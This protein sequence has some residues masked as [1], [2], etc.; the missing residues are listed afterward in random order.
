MKNRKNKTKISTFALVL[1]LTISVTLVALPIVIAHDP[2]WEIT[3]WC[4]IALSH[5]VI[6]RGQTMY[7]VFWSHVE[8]PTGLGAYGDR[9][10]FTVEV[11][12]PDGSKQTLG[13]ISSQDIKS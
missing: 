12:K 11:T 3:T 8:P 5:S 13:P 2:P 10:T 7:A 6:G 4:Y 1:V 9:W